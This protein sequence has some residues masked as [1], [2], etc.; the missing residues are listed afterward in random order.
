MS[1]GEESSQGAQ[2]AGGRRMA[3]GVGLLVFFVVFAGIWSQ[4]QPIANGFVE[5]SLAVRK[6][7]ARYRLASVGVRTQRIEN[8]VL[9]NP[10]RPD[11]TAR[12]VE[13]DLGYGFGLP[14][15]VMIRAQ[16]V[17]LYGD[18]RG[19]ALKLGE[20]DK[21]RDP[22]A[23]GPF[24]LPDIALALT[25][26]RARIETDG[27]PV[28]LTLNGSGNLRSG[29][30]GRLAGLMRDAA[31]GGCTTP[32]IS[33]Y[34]DIRMNESAPRLS[35]PLRIERLVC[36][37]GEAALADMTAALDV[38]GNA[39]L[40]RWTG[41]VD[42]KAEAA[43]LAGWTLAGPNAV[44]RFEGGLNDMAGRGR[45]GFGGLRGGSLQSGAGEIAASFS[46]NAG[47]LSVDGQ[48]SLADL[49]GFDATR[50]R[51][52]GADTPIGPLSVRLA[53]ALAQAQ[54][55]NSARARF[56]LRQQAGAGQATLHAVNFVARSGARLALSEG[57]RFTYGWPAADWSLDG[58]VTSEGGG[59]P[60][61]ALRLA[62]RPGGAISGQLFLDDYA[63]GNARLGLEPVRFLAGRGGKTRLFTTVFLDGPLA[64]GAVR[65]LSLPVAGELDGKG[66]FLLNPA[67][68]PA[69]IRFLQVG[70]F[71]LADTGLTLCPQDGGLVTMRQGR[72]GGGALVRGLALNGRLGT[73]PM[74]LTAGVAR[75][76]PATASFALE[77]P[78][79]FIG[80]AGAQTR[81]AAMR[82]MGRSGGDGLSGTMSGVEASIGA[83]PLLV[84]EGEA[85]WGFAQG[86]LALGGTITVIDAANPDRFNPL[87]S[88]D[89]TVRLANNRIDAAGGFMVP[90]TGALVG[91]VRVAHALGSGEGRADIDVPALRFDEATQPEDVTRLALG[92]VANA[93]GTVSGSG[94]VRWG[95]GGV[96]S[97]GE[98]ATTN[99]ALAAAFGPVTGLSTRLRFTDLIGLVTAPGQVATIASLNPGVAV[100]RGEVRYQLLPGQRVAVEGGRWP[101]AAGELTLLP[102][103]MDFS[104]D[105]PRNLTFRVV[106]LDAGAFIQ[107]LELEN[108]SATGTFDGLLPM[109]F[110]AGG[111]RIVGGILV[112]RQQGLP[113]RIIGQTEALD[114]PCDPARQG[115]TLAY[116]GQVSN[117]NLGRFGKLAFDALKDLQYKCLTVLMDG[118]I[119]GEVVT[120]VAFN[121]VNRGALSSV[122]KPIARQ[123]I[124]LPFLFNIRIAAPF[125]GLMNTARSFVDPGLLIRSHLGDGFETVKQNRLAVQ[126]RES[127]TD[128]SGE[129]K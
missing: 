106:G 116:V 69:R 15:V 34:A 96:T 31:A 90:R 39:A 37:D 51:G 33:L 115:G 112:A 78:V 25:D 38:R 87:V 46:H 113:P 6:V 102:T 89:F 30:R 23:K 61:A 108:I 74:R 22:A 1:A 21:F 10:A 117:E 41:S 47:R 2:R 129:T 107:K 52:I 100:E 70:G 57:G 83:V 126:P 29:F 128:L 92:V 125:R 49:T 8:L 104:A 17:R 5:R 54:R 63:A 99:M 73:S 124:G 121:G 127:E 19:G 114:I 16:G 3:L 67:C 43:R 71:R 72:I 53:D 66:G 110:D 94:Q 75:F 120:Q 122:P 119:D 24:I 60:Q 123:F 56:S 91:Q 98:F 97:S 118:A 80:Q 45:L 109:V 12:T 82:L 65:G 68:A 77:N 26:A 103:E 84:R 32:R 105:H 81:L 27:G 4:R 48:A 9:G 50:L 7:Q 76:S 85:R 42:A 59:L 18:A 58:S 93:R 11:L 88:R 35:G 55:A 20:L 14:R 79:L 36:R 86:A 111:G 40:D 95:A 101:F 44:L 62:P 28:G 64:G 13:I